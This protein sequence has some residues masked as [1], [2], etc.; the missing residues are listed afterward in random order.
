MRKFLAQI[1]LEWLIFCFFLFMLMAYAT[2]AKFLFDVRYSIKKL[3]DMEEIFG[4]WDKPGSCQGHADSH[5]H[6]DD[7]SS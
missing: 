6:Q 1:R 7:G 3:I 5:D 2:W 4:L